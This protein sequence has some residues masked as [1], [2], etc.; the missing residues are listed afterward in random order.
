MVFNSAAAGELQGDGCCGLVDSVSR[1]ADRRQLRGKGLVRKTLVG[2]E[3]ARH[4][5]ATKARQ[6]GIMLVKVC[7]YDVDLRRIGAQGFLH[8][9]GIKLGRYLHML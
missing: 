9:E 5:C 8:A 3:A 1:H 7:I 6:G 2:P 4:D